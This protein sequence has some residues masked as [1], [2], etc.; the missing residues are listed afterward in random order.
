M[1][2]CAAVGCDNNSFK[3]DKNI[4]I[5][6]FRLPRDKSLR[7]QW[8]ANLK[9]QNLPKPENVHVCHLHFEES[10]FKR[11]LEVWIFCYVESMHET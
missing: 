2:Y 8:I 5:S 3:K 1:V 9:R 7:K 4:G 6:F 10:C 11:D